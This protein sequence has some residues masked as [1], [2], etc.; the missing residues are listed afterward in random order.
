MYVPEHRVPVRAVVAGRDGTVW[1]RGSETQAGLASWTVLGADG[2]RLAS[3]D[4]PMRVTVYR[5]DRD[6]VW[7]VEHDTLDVPYVVRYRV[8]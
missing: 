6:F 7:G 4:I 1:L 3:I 8:R 2:T 5:A